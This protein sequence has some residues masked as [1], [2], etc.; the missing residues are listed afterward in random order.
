M[1]S[2]QG[3]PKSD[4]SRNKVDL[5]GPRREAIRLAHMVRRGALTSEQASALIAFTQQQQLDAVKC[6]LSPVLVESAAEHRNA[7]LRHFLNVVE[8]K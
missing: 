8:K 6:G 4:S 3:S 2:G 5:C 7:V 1:L